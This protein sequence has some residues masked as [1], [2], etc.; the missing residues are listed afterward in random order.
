MTGPLPVVGSGGVVGG[1]PARADLETLRDGWRIRASEEAKEAEYHRLKYEY[2]T[3]SR[4]DYVKTAYLICAEQLDRLLAFSN[5]RQPT[6]NR[7]QI[8][9]ED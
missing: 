5:E 6:P 9:R 3:A 7:P 1:R 2:T 4:H 8:S